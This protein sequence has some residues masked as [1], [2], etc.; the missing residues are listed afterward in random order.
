MA[1]HIER[2]VLKWMLWY[3]LYGMYCTVCIVYNV[4]HAGVGSQVVSWHTTAAVVVGT[5]EGLL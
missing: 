5:A 1:V 2:C 4:T 3:V